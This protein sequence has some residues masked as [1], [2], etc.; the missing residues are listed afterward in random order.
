MKKKHDFF[1]LKMGLILDLVDD[2]LFWF[3]TR[4]ARSDSLSAYELV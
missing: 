3:I 2:D 1:I 4:L